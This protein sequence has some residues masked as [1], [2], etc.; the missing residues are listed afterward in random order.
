MPG[1]DA[2]CDDSVIRDVD[3]SLR[4]TALTCAVAHSES[5]VLARGA[6][7]KTRVRPVWPNVRTAY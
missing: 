5:H 1:T 3:P 6:N 4:A 7:L 2:R